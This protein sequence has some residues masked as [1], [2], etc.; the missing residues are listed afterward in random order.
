MWTRIAL[1]A[2]CSAATSKS[3]VLLL[4]LVVGT[5]SG[6]LFFIL[7]EKYELVSYCTNLVDLV[8]E[9]A[10]RARTNSSMESRQS[11]IWNS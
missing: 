3:D 7:S 1:F 8:N 6:D 4:D 11:R 2:H 5:G 9:I 10:L